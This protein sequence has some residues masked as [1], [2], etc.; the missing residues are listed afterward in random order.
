MTSSS[1]PA[2]RAL[3]LA[4]GFSL[5]EL[6][7]AMVLGLIVLGA[8]I[9]VFQSNQRTFQANEGLNRV[10]EGARVAF[11]L[12]SRDLR[13]A[14]GSGCSS[15]SVVETTGGFSDTYKDT[16]VTGSAD[17]LV[18]TSGE[19]SAYRVT[20]STAG[21]VT[22][23]ADQI[24]DASDAFAKDDWLLLCNARKTFLIKATDVSG[25]DLTFATLPGSYVPT[26][27]AFLGTAAS[28]VVA[29]LRSTR[30]FVKTN[31]RGGKSLYTQRLGGAEEEVADGIQALAL[32]YLEDGA[33]D[34][35]AA[36]TDWTNVIAVRMAMTLQGQDTAGSTLKV[37]GSTLDRTASTVVSLRGRTL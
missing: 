28:V 8:A 21:S 6:M 15:A 22:L 17:E 19:D 29:R 14:G 3:R 12:M 25:L 5:I 30:W 1:N 18:V 7:V 4:G 32:T 37:D 20:A 26:S 31:A 2:P 33:A 10:Q 27:D 11:E 9:A 35:T 36:P 13:A 16:P 24:A 23:D 34:Y